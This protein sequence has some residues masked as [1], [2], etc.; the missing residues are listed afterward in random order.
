MSTLLRSATLYAA[1]R[2]IVWQC[3]EKLRGDGRTF[4]VLQFS[5]GLGHYDRW[6]YIIAPAKSICDGQ[7]SHARCEVEINGVEKKRWVP[8][9]IGTRERE[10]EKKRSLW[11][12][13]GI[14][15]IELE[16]K[17]QNPRTPDNGCKKENRLVKKR[18]SGRTEEKISR[19]AAYPRKCSGGG[20]GEATAERILHYE[21][22]DVSWAI[23]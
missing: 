5:V 8:A 14:R 22:R 12:K 6:L 21:K 17:F 4:R 7:L 19:D 3:P 16:K 23:L 13:R 2:C 11:Y 1:F 20:F 18:R 9:G 15:A 10:R